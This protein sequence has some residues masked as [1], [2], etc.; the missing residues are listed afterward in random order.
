M[1]LEVAVLNVRP[2]RD[3]M[4]QT[5]FSEAQKIIASMPGYIEHQL[6]KCLEVEHQYLLLVKWQT[7]AD[8]TE[9]FRRSAE[10]QDW[11]AL[12]HH[13]YDPFPV[14]H[15]YELVQPGSGIN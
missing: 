11:K 9:G 1:I 8:H 2:D 14:V 5:A 4:F 15:H 12:L 10:Y 6:Q 3:E 7:L 13:F